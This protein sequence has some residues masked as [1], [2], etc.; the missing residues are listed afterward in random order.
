MRRRL[1]E[2]SCADGQTNRQ[3]Q[4]NINVLAEVISDSEFWRRHNNEIKIVHRYNVDIFDLSM[5]ICISTQC[6][7]VLTSKYDYTRKPD[8]FTDRKRSNVRVVTSQ[9]NAT[10]ETNNAVHLCDQL[11]WADA[12]AASSTVTMDEAGLYL[13]LTRWQHTYRMSCIVCSHAMRDEN[14]ARFHSRLGC[15][16]VITS[17]SLSSTV[18]ACHMSLGLT[19]IAN[20]RAPW[21]DNN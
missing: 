10:M 7:L 19:F 15:C 18:S 14:S 20:L 2:S 12:R 3:R 11:A 5:R 17:S 9:R 1:F 8:S 13:N 21:H 16:D 6:I 4:K